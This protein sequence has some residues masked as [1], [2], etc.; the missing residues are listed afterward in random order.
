MSNLQSSILPSSTTTAAAAATTSML[1]YS[2]SMSGSSGVDDKAGLTTISNTNANATTTNTT[3]NTNTTTGNKK[4]DEGTSSHSPPR[5]QK[6]TACLPIVYGS[7]AFYLGK[8]ADEFQTHEWT[9]Y[10]RG[11][12]QEDLSA[13]ISKVVFQLHASFAQPIRELANPPF[14]V[15]ERGWGE[16]EAQIRILWKD[17]SEK[18]TVVRDRKFRTEKD[19]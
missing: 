11:P 14:E 15:T 1:S 12:N 2:T 9:L 5:L 19:K 13:V 18:P 8:K 16:F 10:V 17:P 6:T 4:K 3:T 7:V